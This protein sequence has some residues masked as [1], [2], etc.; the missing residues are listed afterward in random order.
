MGISRMLT[1]KSIIIKTL[2]VASTTLASR[3]LGI[4][5]EILMVAFLGATDLSDAFLTAFKIPNSLRRIFAE[6]ALSAALIPTVVS[7]IKK[8]G[9]EGVSRL[10]AIAFVVF[11]GMVL[12]LCGLVIIYAESII[13]CIAP[14]FSEWQIHVSIPFLQI[15]MPFIFFISSSALLAGALQGVGHFLI[16]SLGSIILNCIFIGSIGLCLHYQLPVIY[17]CLGII[18][19]GFIQFVAHFITYSLY[20]FHLTRFTKDDVRNFGHVFTKFLGSLLSVSIM[21]ISLFVDTSFASYLSKGS[22][23][24]IYYANRFMNIPLGVFG[25]AFSTIM[26]SHFSRIYNEEREKV[27]FYLIEAFKLVLWVTAPISLFMSFFSYDIF[28]TIF[29]SEKFTIIQV[30]QASAILIAFIIGLFFFSLNKIVL[31]VYYAHHDTFVP[32]LIALVTNLVNI[33]LNYIFIARFQAVGIALATTL[34]TGILQTLLLFIGLR[35]CH[36]I[37]TPFA[38]YLSFIVRYMVQLLVIMP[39]FFLSFYAV[40]WCIIVTP[41]GHLLLKTVFL[42]AWTMPLIAVFFALLFKTRRYF[43]IHAYFLGDE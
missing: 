18:F 41:Y 27:V 8:S 3:L 23:S 32:G 42:W 37:V 13:R 36:G 17:L 4:V 24:L 15:M 10:I 38:E 9:Q 11:E 28:Y 25:I 5:R 2:Q 30:S 26:L 21:E 14:G 29:L 19:A 43:G 1:K 31:N 35:R 12:S 39:L 33:V 40:R 16:P 6:G 22:I 34:S 20:G 7:T